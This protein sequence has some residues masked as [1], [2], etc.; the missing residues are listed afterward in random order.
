MKMHVDGRRAA[1]PEPEAGNHAETLRRQPQEERATA[2][3]D[4]I[5]HDVDRVLERDAL[6][7]R[8]RKIEELVAGLVDRESESLIEGVG[9]EHGPQPR[10]QPDEGGPESER[11]RKHQ[12][13]DRH[14][15]AAKRRT[16]QQ[17]LNDEADHAEREVEGAKEARERVGVSGEALVGDEAQLERRPLRHDGHEEDERR[18]EPEIRAGGN[19]AQSIA[20][21][22]AARRG[23]RASRPC[24]GF[25]RWQSRQSARRRQSAPP[26]PAACSPCR[27]PDR[28]DSGRRRRR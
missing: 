5:D 24:G 28:R 12:N 17:Q 2:V 25:G 26:G 13:G 19:L 16:G 9:H 18:H 11:Q 20:Q 21:R 15:E 22:I 8:N 3:G 14:A 23:R 27:R 4:T 6:R 1:Q 10:Q 7:R